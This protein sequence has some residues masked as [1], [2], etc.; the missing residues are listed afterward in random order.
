MCKTGSMSILIIAVLWSTSAFA[1]DVAQ[2]ELTPAAKA[3][4]A[5]LERSSRWQAPDTFSPIYLSNNF[6]RPLPDMNFEDGSLL[7]RVS[8]LRRVSLLTVAEIGEAQFFFGLNNDGL[9]GLHFNIDKKKRKERQLELLRMP[10]LLAKE[11]ESA[12]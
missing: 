11:K 12:R 1:D 7:Q 5:D 2:A 9:L 6:L 3:F 8:K 10:Y 4:I